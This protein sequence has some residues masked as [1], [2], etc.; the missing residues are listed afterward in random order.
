MDGCRM[1]SASQPCQPCVSLHGRVSRVMSI[2]SVVSAMHGSVVLRMRIGSSC[3]VGIL[4]LVLGHVVS[5]RGIPEIGESK[6][7]KPKSH[8]QNRTFIE[9]LLFYF[10]GEVV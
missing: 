9:R 8:F 6:Q 1:A 3:R 10:F 7:L 4:P 5:D 2:I